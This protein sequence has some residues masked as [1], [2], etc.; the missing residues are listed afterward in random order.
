MLD[1]TQAS[2]RNLL[3][4]KAS[5]IQSA[6]EVYTQT[7]TYKFWQTFSLMDVQIQERQKSNLTVI[8]EATTRYANTKH[9]SQIFS[10]SILKKTK[11]QSHF[12]QEKENLAG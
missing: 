5:I 2:Q 1:L 8:Y 11:N 9:S 3:H 10:S 4:E 12:K 7:Y 6:K